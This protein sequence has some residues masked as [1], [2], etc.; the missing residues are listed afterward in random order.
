MFHQVLKTRLC[1]RKTG[2]YGGIIDCT[3]QILRTE[4]VRSFTRGYVPTV[5]SI[6]PNAGLD[7]AVYEVGGI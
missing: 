6:I 1:L 3:R 2:Q 4:G 5:L 7:L